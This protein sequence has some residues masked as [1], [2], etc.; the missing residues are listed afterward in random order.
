MTLQC[1]RLTVSHQVT[2]SHRQIAGQQ[3]WATGVGACELKT[4]LA[5]AHLM[6]RRLYQKARGVGMHEW[7][8]PWSNLMMSASR[9]TDHTS[10]AP[11]RMA[12]ISSS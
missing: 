7:T 12:S 8:H 11:H 5:P 4:L 1:L 2:K 3:S 9:S 6:C 10:E